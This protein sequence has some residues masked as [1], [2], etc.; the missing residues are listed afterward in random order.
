M[1][2]WTMIV[3]V[4][5]IGCGAGVAESY[6]KSKRHAKSARSEDDALNSELVELRSRVEVLEKIVTDENYQLEQELD[7]L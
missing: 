5:A 3:C 7:R 1:D 4:V 2:L 6:F